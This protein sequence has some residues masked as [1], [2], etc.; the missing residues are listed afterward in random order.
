MKIHITI[1]L[2]ATALLVLVTERAAGQ[3]T[4][5]LQ[6]SGATDPATE[7]FS[8]F[9]QRS[10]SGPVINDLG[11]NAWMTAT[12]AGGGPAYYTQTLTPQQQAEL[13]GASWDLSVTLRVVQSPPPA[14]TYVQ[15]D[16]GSMAYGMAFSINANGDP[17]VDSYTLTGAGSTYNNYQL[18]Y[19]ASTETASLWVNNVEVNSDQPGFAYNYPAQLSWGEENQGG[20]YQANW[21]SV[22]L[23]ITPEPSA[24]SLLLLGGG[25]F[26]L[27][28]HPQQKEFSAS[29]VRLT[30][31]AQMKTPNL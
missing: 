8:Y 18:I 12:G 4:I 21:N 2:L 14:D 27:C 19:D 22:S 31:E 28:S 24:I 3:A 16:T 10:L 23:E 25:F 5:L 26:N 13:G 1:A 30:M 20:P 17:V 9:G 6:H 29:K 7:G 15:F 11:M